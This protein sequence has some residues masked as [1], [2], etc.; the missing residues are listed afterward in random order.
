MSPLQPFQ[1]KRMTNQPPVQFLV[2][3]D[4][5]RKQRCEVKQAE[6]DLRLIQTRMARTL[7]IEKL[8]RKYCTLKSSK[9]ESAEPLMMYVKKALIRRM[10]ERWL[11]QRED[12]LKSA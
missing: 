2:P 6:R 4:P 8:F 7:P 1:L 5:I 3:K 11:V 12:K 10:G 9:W